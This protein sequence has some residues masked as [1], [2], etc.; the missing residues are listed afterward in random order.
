MKKQHAAAHRHAFAASWIEGRG[1][2][3][4]TAQM[5]CR[6]HWLLAAAACCLLCVSCC[7]LSVS[8][9]TGCP[10]RQ[11][12]LETGPAGARQQPGQALTHTPGHTLSH[13]QQPGQALAG[14]GYA[15]G[16]QRIAECGVR[17]PATPFAP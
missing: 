4:P 8:A 7:G 10:T 11:H 16:T 15:D 6:C 5:V 13:T 1:R 2:R 12:W 9:S 14:A 17:I 3:M